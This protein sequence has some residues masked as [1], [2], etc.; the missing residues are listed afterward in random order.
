MK[1]SLN[2]LFILISTSFLLLSCAGGVGGGALDPLSSTRVGAGTPASALSVIYNGDGNTGGAVPVDPNGYQPGQTVTVLGNTGS[3]VDSGFS[4]AGWNTQVDGSG[5]TYAP[6][7]T[8]TMG[9]ANATLYALWTSSTTYTVTYQTNVDTDGNPYSGPTPTDPNSY[10]Q[11]QT[12]TVK[13]IGSFIYDG[14]TFAG[15]NTAANGSGTAY[16]AAATFTMGPAN[17]VLYGQWTTTP[18][19]VTYYGN[20]NT[21]GTQP[22]DLTTYYWESSP[23]VLANSGSLAK[24]GNTFVGWNT[25]ADGSGSTYFPGQYI[26]YIEA[27]V[28]LYAIWYSGTTYTVTYNSNG[29]TGTV[30]VDSNNYMPGQTA[31]LQR[32][33]SLSGPGYTPFWNYW[34]TQANGGGSTYFLAPAYATT[35]QISNANVT[36][37]AIYY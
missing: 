27:N 13:G 30:P 8:F 18:Y 16:A 23:L 29:G 3:L 14:F 12:V 32:G 6:G 1:S 7:Q 34:A 22:V 31:T 20:T 21:S 11:G 25:E 28:S 24:S 19:T 5:T 4:F 36:L 26:P 10:L 33:G 2:L 37:Y 17:V 9:S 15:W 35:L